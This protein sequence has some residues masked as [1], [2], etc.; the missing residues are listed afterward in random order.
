[1][2]ASTADSVAGLKVSPGVRGP[3]AV[4]CRNRDASTSEILALVSHWY[5]REVLAASTSNTACFMNVLN[6]RPGERG[7][8]ALASA[9]DGDGDWPARGV[10]LVAGWAGPQLR[11][12]GEDGEA[13]PFDCVLQ[14]SPQL[15]T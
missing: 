15:E 6:L 14:H 8:H 9:S 7:S 13:Q 5:R 2:L 10:V 4:S 3:D 12:R 1:M 11:R